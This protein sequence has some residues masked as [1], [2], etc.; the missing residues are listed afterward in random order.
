MAILLDGD[1]S[2]REAIVL[3]KDPSHTS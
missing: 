1:H 2:L 3:G